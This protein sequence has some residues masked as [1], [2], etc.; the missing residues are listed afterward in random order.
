MPDLLKKMTESVDVKEIEEHYTKLKGILLNT[1]GLFLDLNALPTTPHNLKEIFIKWLIQVNLQRI[2]QGL[3][4]IVT[5][6]LVAKCPLW[7]VVPPPFR[8]MQLTKTGMFNKPEVKNVRQ[9][10]TPG[11]INKKP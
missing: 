10:P 3:D 9:K 4:P 5:P 2:E 1:S 8:N 11:L 6:S 7:A